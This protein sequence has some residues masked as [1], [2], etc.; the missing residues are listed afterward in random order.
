[1]KDTGLLW[2]VKFVFRKISKV[3]TSLHE[4]YTLSSTS[5]KDYGKEAI[6]AMMAKMNANI[7]GKTK[8]PIFIFAGYPCEMEDFLRVNPGL[9]RRIPNFLQFN[10]YTPIELAE[11]TSKI[12]LTYEMSYPHG[13]L[14]M[15]VDCFASLPKE[16]RAKWNGGLCGLLLDYI[17]NE[18]VKRLDLD[19]SI[20]DI[21]RFKK[22]DIEL[23]IA[24]FLRDKSS[25]DKKF[26]EQGTR[27]H[28]TELCNKWTQTAE[29]I[30]N[31]LGVG[32]VF[33][34]P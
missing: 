25:G 9:S 24:C 28:N 22:Q 6:E 14:D 12:L 1:M 26:S 16:I 8:N 10:D 13:V 34:S 5:G 31:I 7:D 27:T 17:Q 32:A 20:Q 23:G 18:Q 3:A 30:M 33:S 4:A 21:N 19:C 2:F 15:F 29:V 11:I